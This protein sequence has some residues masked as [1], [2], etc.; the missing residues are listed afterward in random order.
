[1]K[2]SLFSHYQ[3]PTRRDE[4]HRHFGASVGSLCASMSTTA[5]APS[6]LAFEY[7]YDK[8]KVVITGTRRRRATRSKPQ[9]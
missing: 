8:G 3:S 1:M 5:G 7:G 2:K 6:L 9:R 4:D